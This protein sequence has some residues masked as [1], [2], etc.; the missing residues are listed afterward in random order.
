MRL[1]SLF[2]RQR[3]LVCDGAVSDVVDAEM[4]TLTLLR[5][6]TPPHAYGSVPLLYSQASGSFSSSA[7]MVVRSHMID[8]SFVGVL[9]SVCRHA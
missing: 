9:L 8:S 3:H 1:R 7:G 2:E 4:S 5:L 6:S